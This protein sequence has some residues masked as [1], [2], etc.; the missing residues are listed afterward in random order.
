MSAVKKWTAVSA[1]LAGLAITANRYQP[2]SKRG[3]L[4]MYSFSFGVFATEL[5]LQLI[6][7]QF[8]ALAALTRKLAPRVR[9]VSWLVSALSWLGLFG[10]SR[11]GHEANGP[12]KAA[13]HR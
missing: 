5:P 3:Y 9:A 1:S 6:A 7:G 13:L 10:L 8:A 12:L 4:S 11:I 2:L